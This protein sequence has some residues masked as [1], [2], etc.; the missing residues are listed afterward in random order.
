MRKLCVVGASL[1]V[2]ACGG[3]GGDASCPPDT[4]MQAVQA[5]VFNGCTV[6][7]NGGCHVAAPFGANLDLTSA[8]AYVD[9]VHAPSQ[10]S[11]GKWRVEPGDLDGSFLWRKL[12]NNLASDGSEGLPMPRDTRDQWA[13]LS[14][15]QLASVRCWIAS[16]A[17]DP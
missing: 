3:G 15:A 8:N 2:V 16:G 5:Q 4:S 9:L 12:T 10:S 17:S 7:G 14:D 6:T 1:L 11:P 13:P